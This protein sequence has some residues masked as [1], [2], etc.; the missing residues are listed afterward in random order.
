[1]LVV[2]NKTFS[3]ATSIGSR[4]NTSSYLVVIVL[5]RLNMPVDLEVDLDRIMRLKC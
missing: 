4:F 2:V 3:Y 1:M 5:V